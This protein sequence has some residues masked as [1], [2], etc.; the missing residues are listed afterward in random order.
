MAYGEGMKKTRTVR[1]VIASI[2][3]KCTHLFVHRE[4]CH[5][6]PFLRN[7]AIPGTPSATLQRHGLSD[8]VVQISRV[9]H[10]AKM[11]ENLV[12]AWIMLVRGILRPKHA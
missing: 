12:F 1:I 9:P 2:K 8:G 3:N 4:S 11:Q 6:Y 7:K 5:V 10:V